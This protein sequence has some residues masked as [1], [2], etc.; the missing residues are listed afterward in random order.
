MPAP[1]APGAD[2]RAARADYERGIASIAQI[3]ARCG[4]TPQAVTNRRA[5]E[6]WAA[7]LAQPRAIQR[8][9]EQW[10][11]RCA[12]LG[13]TDQTHQRRSRLA[14]AALAQA[15]SRG[16]PDDLAAPL[17]GMTRETF[18]LWRD[19]DEKL[20]QLLDEAK[21]DFA[22]SRIQNLADAADRGD[23]QTVR[24]WL[25]RHSAT[26]EHF[27]PAESA[28]GLQIHVAF[29]FMAQP[30]AAPAEGPVIEAQ[31]VEDGAELQIE[32]PKADK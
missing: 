17:A 16:L 25:E 28:G 29:G 3:A 21:A 24:W 22:N 11:D 1:T 9:S 4:V 2:W 14:A 19:E 27:R 23:A 15:V 30:N 13:I 26:R 10:L 6:G 8:V 20:R 12:A 18:A 31:V 7:P 32:G 5:R